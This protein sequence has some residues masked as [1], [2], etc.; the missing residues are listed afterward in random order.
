MDGYRGMWGEGMADIEKVVK[1]L[2]Q[3]TVGSPSCDGCPYDINSSKCMFLLHTDALDLLKEQRETIDEL[4]SAAKALKQI[5][6]CRDCKHQVDRG[7]KYKECDQHF[8][9]AKDDWFCADGE[10]RTE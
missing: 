1:A 5:V 6:H 8:I 4:T 7:R 9:I 2:E 3:C 10:R